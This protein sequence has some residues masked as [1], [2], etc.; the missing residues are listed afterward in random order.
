MYDIV[1]IT[2][3]LDIPR[4]D[5]SLVT[6]ISST[7]FTCICDIN[8]WFL[9][10]KAFS[11]VI[12]LLLILC[13][14]LVNIFQVMGYLPNSKQSASHTPSTSGFLHLSISF[15]SLGQLSYFHQKSLFL[16]DDGSSNSLVTADVSCS[17]ELSDPYSMGINYP[18]PTTNFTQAVTLIWFLRSSR[19]AVSWCGLM[20]FL[21]LALLLL[22]LSWI[23]SAPR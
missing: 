1:C 23:F 7:Y 6:I 9:I 5:M 10:G 8:Y 4:F 15:F 13:K 2:S 18:K 16:F 19:L 11:Y 17:D 21:F 22:R 12:G 20:N 14:E 3:L